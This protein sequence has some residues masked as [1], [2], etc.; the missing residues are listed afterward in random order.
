MAVVVRTQSIPF[1]IKANGAGNG[2]GDHQR[3]RCQESLFGVWV[4]APVEITVTGKNCRGVK[5][6]I[7]YLLLDGRIKSTTHAVAGGTGIANNTKTQLFQLGQ[8]AC[9]LKIESGH[10]RPRGK[11]GL[12]PRLALQAQSISIAGQQAGSDDIAWVAG[13]GA[14]GNCGND[15]RTI[16]HLAGLFL[17]V[18]GNALLMQFCRGQSPMGAGRACQRSL[19][20]TQVKSQH[21]FIVNVLQVIAPETSGSGIFFHQGNLFWRPTG[22]FQVV[23]GLL[24]D[25]EQPGRGSELRGHIGNSGPVADGQTGTARTKKLQPAGNHAGLAQKFGQ[26]ENDIGGRNTRLALSDQFD[27]DNIRQTHHGWTT[28]HNRLRFQT[29]DADGDDTQGIN[30]RGVT[31]GTHTSI[32]KGDTV[33]NLNDRRHLLQ[34][35]LVHDAVPGRYHIHITECRF[36]PLN[37]V[38]TIFIAPRLNDLV[39]RHGIGVRAIMLHRQGV[40]DDQLGGHYRVDFSRVTALPGNGIT[41]PGQVNQ[42]RLAENIMTNDSGWIPGKILFTTTFNYLA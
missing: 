31:V 28:K 27:P 11:R 12:Y 32:G 19:H 21:T 22:Q 16:R 6:P 41:Q 7:K 25:I 33:T 15:N 20:C 8:Q 3:W 10:L 30:M 42:R 1:N 35:D 4:D 38:E 14:T 24:I 29:T 18:A 37:K 17:P 5:I 2:V 39:V 26:G 34:I 9:S 36:A 13:I 40:I 23:N